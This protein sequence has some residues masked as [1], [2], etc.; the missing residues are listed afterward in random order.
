MSMKR[1]ICAAVATLLLLFTTLLPSGAFAEETQED[2]TPEAKAAILYEMTTGTVLYEKNADTQLPPASMTK[3]MTAILVLE[4]NPELEGELTVDKRAVSSYY[5][6]SMEPMRH[7]YAGEVI[8]Y[9]DCMNYM[10]IA[11]GNEAATSF[12]FELAGDM[13]EFAKQMTAKAKELGCKNTEFRDPTGISSYNLTTPRD[14]A[15]IA[16]YAMTFDKF[17]EIVCKPGG[18][19]PPSNKREKGFDYENS[20]PLLRE[21]PYITPYYGYIKGI[22]TGWTPSAGYCLTCCMEKDNLTWISVVMG[23]EDEA[24]TEDGEVIRGDAPVTVR[25][26]GLTDGITADDLKKPVNGLLLAGVIIAGI[27]IAV[28]A[29]VLYRKKHRRE[30]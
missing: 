22:K 26:L 2:V 10:L 28:I 21:D 8:S 1:K 18:T 5:C 9:E 24:V 13:S 3:V 12:A 20:D 15:K 14:M 27:V 29:A 4:Q 19:V 11:S 23:V 16:E 7:L 30:M 25:L 17:R 6:S